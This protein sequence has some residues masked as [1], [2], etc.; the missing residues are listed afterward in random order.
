[1]YSE[2]DKASDKRSLLWDELTHANVYDYEWCE[3]GFIAQRRR[4][5]E[6]DIL[7]LFFLSAGC[8]MYVIVQTSY[9]CA[10]STIRSCILYVCFHLLI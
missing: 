4:G 7:F 3:I 1:M 10:D 5:N 2:R 8:T 9:E 6:N